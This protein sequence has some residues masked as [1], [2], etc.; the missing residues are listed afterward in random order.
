MVIDSSDKLRLVVAKE[1]LDS[2]LQ[3]PGNDLVFIV[4]T[5]VTIATMVTLFSNIVPHDVTMFHVT[6]V[7]LIQSVPRYQRSR[8]SHSDLQQQNGHQRFPFPLPGKRNRIY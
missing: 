8:G 4:T 7:T 3:H 2:F 6:M 5:L 1:E